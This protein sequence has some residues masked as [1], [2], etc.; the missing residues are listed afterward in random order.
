MISYKYFSEILLPFPSLPEQEKIANYLTSIDK[1]IETIKK[2][3]TA[4]QGFKKGLL[5][6][7]FV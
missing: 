2:E 5:Q 3:I 4:T 6:Q 7:M 1:K